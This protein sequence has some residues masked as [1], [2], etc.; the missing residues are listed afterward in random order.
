MV[1]FPIACGDVLCQELQTG[2]PWLF[3]DHVT[4]TTLSE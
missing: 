3:L 4:L 2:P 1:A